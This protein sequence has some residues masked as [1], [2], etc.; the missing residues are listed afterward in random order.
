MKAPKV[1]CT[2][3]GV[4]HSQDRGLLWGPQTYLVML[5]GAVNEEGRLLL[6]PLRDGVSHCVV[7]L[8]PPGTVLHAVFVVHILFRSPE[9]DKAESPWGGLSLCVVASERTWEANMAAVDINCALLLKTFFVEFTKTERGSSSSSSSSSYQ[10]HII[11]TWEDHELH[12]GYFEG[13]K[14]CPDLQR[15]RGAWP[16]QLEISTWPIKLSWVSPGCEDK[17]HP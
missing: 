9:E 4:T 14:R 13:H 3:L 11:H 16:A 8:W 2:H 1:G 10:L 17:A 5:Q 12:R 6:Y 15:P 7:G